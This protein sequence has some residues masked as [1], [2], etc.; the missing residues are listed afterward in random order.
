MRWMFREPGQIEAADR[1]KT[2][3]AIRA[4]WKAF[5]KNADRIAASFS[6]K[7]KFDLPEWMHATLGKIDRDL[8]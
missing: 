4:W 1:K 5:E 7:E 8:M 2:E 6:K 3:A